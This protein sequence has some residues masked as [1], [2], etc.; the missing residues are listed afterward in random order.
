MM[1]MFLN[2]IAPWYAGK[3]MMDMFLNDIAPWCCREMV[4]DVFLNYIAPWY[5]GKMM[6][7]VFLNDIAPWC[8]REMVMD[9]FL[10]GITPWCCDVF[11]NGI[12]PWC[13]MVNDDDRFFN[14]TPWLCKEND[15]GCVS[16]WYF[17][18]MDV[19]LN[20]FLPLVLQGTWC[21]A[22]FSVILPIGVA[23]KMMMDRYLNIAPWCCR[24]HDDRWV[25]RHHPL[26]L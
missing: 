9:V 18:L 20:N 13:C 6:M 14:I 4:M 26:V 10:I 11:L 22:G 15:V 5:A 12:T 24:E 2:D 1:D 8:C 25:S 7:D 16:Q 3:M 17:S 23:G 21:W 19:F